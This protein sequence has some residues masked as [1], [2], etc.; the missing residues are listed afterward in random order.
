MVA[1]PT[2]NCAM[3]LL[4]VLYTRSSFASQFED[5]ASFLPGVIQEL[6]KTGVVSLSELQGMT[7][8]NLQN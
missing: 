3:G 1:V 6:I 7:G 4:C 2:I 5:P 8:I